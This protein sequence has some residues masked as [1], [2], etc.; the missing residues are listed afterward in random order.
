MED[1][2]IRVE[3]LGVWSHGT[4]LL[5]AGHSIREAYYKPPIINYRHWV[6]SLWGKAPQWLI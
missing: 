4:I 3:G 5:G 2:V 1:V 6:V